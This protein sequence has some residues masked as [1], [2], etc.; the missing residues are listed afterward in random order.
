MVQRTH[1]PGHTLQELIVHVETHKVLRDDGLAAQRGTGQR[2]DGRHGLFEAAAEVGQHSVLG[3]HLLSNRES[4]LHR[5]VKVG[6]GLFFHLFIKGG[7][8]YQQGGALP[9]FNKRFARPCV[10]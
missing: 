3:T 8:M 5:R 4:L 6:Y 10:R 7:L 2:P 9:S 1:D